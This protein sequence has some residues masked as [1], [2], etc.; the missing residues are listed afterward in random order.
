MFVYIHATFEL[1]GRV[2]RLRAW[3]PVISRLRSD[4]AHQQSLRRDH[5]HVCIHTLYDACRR[6]GSVEPDAPR[7]AWKSSTGSFAATDA[8]VSL[9]DA[10]LRATRA[11]LVM[12]MG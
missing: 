1:G 10:Q 11:R 3:I 9:R 8:R 5:G 4:H 2:R 6:S 12:G 7:R